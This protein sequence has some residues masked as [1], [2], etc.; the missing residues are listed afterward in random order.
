MRAVCMGNS[1]RWAVVSSQS[2]CPPLPSHFS[3]VGSGQWAVGS[4]IPAILA[5]S[6][7]WVVGGS[8]GLKHG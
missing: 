7:Q 1:G 2:H 5:C 8:Q 6:G 4:R 3:S